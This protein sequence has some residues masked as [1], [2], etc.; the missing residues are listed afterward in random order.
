MAVAFDPTS[1]IPVDA[2]AF[3]PSSAVP[4]EAAAPAA[5]PET[6]GRVVGLSERALVHGLG[7][8]V[9]TPGALASL[10]DRAGGSV[11]DYVRGLFGLA[12]DATPSAPAPTT[13]SD[14]ATL[15][16]DTMGLPKPQTPAERIVS[17]TVSA[18]PVAVVAP[19]ALLPNMMGNAAS[20]T[21]AE[22]GGSPGWQTA[23]GLVAGGVPALGSAGAAAVRGVV[24]GG[25][26]GAADMSEN[27]ANAA[28]NNVPLTVGQASGSK[29]AQKAEAVSGSMWGGGPI[30]AAADS[31]TQGIANRVNDIVDNLNQG[32]ATLTPTGAG[33][34]INTGV[35]A[36]K[37]SMKAVEG[38]A[39]DK[40]DQLVPP[41]TPINVSNTQA[42]L[43]ELA[44]PTPGAEATTGALIPKDISDMQANMK[45]DAAN[46]TMPY[47]ALVALRTKVGNSIDWGFAPSNPTVNGQLKQVY[48]ALTKDRNTGAGAVSP[49]AQEAVTGASSLYATN[50]AKRDL[51]DSIVEKNG[52]PEAVYTAATNGTKQG[53]TKISSVM[54]AIDPGSQNVVRATILNRLGQATPGAQNAAGDAFNASTFLTNWN[55]LA[56]ESK[57][58]LFGTGGTAGDL[59]SSLDSLTDTMTTLRNSNALKNPSG[60]GSLLGH[61]V[62]LMGLLSEVGE[63][64]FAG[65]LKGA[66]VAT[67]AGLAAVGVNNL[68]ARALTNPR[69]ARWLAQSTK[70]PPSALPT[71]VAQLGQIGDRTNDQDAKDLAA[72]LKQQAAQ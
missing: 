21:V 39:Y 18:A 12:S 8:L 70:L 44:T 13:G 1:A 20:Q 10:A 30:A 17:N 25:A 64:A 66:A 45:T 32:G 14:A 58:A 26:A 29:L 9:D 53:A 69:T 47:S 36:T 19:E 7:T 59:R 52:G 23:A 42:K 38:A 51:L 11:H 61:A 60:T 68:A 31:Q 72:Y 63:K 2:P 15:F 46:G 43:T 22:S 49:E 55:R 41:V 50:Q 33:T 6:A 67:G 34:A 3:D 37:A 71:A 5:P 28:N 65:N 4:V 62:P 40:V 56:P 54:T 57:N 24:R 27:L 35:A 16:S 48:G